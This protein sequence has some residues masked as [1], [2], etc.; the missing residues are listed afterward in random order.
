MIR[1]SALPKLP[2][3]SVD[4]T[5]H[6][7]SLVDELDAVFQS[8]LERMQSQARDAFV[9]EQ[10]L[11]NILSDHSGSSVLGWDIEKAITPLAAYQALAQRIIDQLPSALGLSRT[12]QRHQY[13]DLLV[14][15]DEPK[16]T[17]DLM[18]DYQARIDYARRLTLRQFVDLTIARFAP[19]KDPDVAEACAA[20]DLLRAFVIQLPQDLV[21]PVQDMG[22]AKILPMR[23]T[24]LADDVR[25]V[26]PH[27]T[28]QVVARTNYAIST[29]ARLSGKALVASRMVEMTRDFQSFVEKGYGVYEQN[30]TFRGGSEVQ[31]RLLADWVDYQVSDD[32]YGRLRNTMMEADPRLCFVPAASVFTEL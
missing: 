3:E 19:D 17:G 22:I 26:M 18:K 2:T 4:V 1:R 20:A 23:I 29:V 24:R 21:V 5:S 32:L 7:Y 15:P 25:W 30:Q 14:W 9:L 13:A 31:K 8:A 11:R 27:L 28:A 10:A 16:R 6:L 12:P